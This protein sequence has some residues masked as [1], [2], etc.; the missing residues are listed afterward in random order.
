MTSAFFF[1]A[2]RRYWY[3]LIA[4]LMI[5]AFA[6][7]AVGSVVPKTYDAT[8]QILLSAPKVTDPTDSSLYV[9]DRM[10]TYAEFIESESVLANARSLMGTD[11]STAFLASH[12]DARVEV[13]TVLITITASWSD[14]QGAAD[15][16]N[17]VARSYAEVAPRLDN[18]D[19]PILRSDTVEA[20]VAPN[21]D[22][23]L[24]PMALMT[25]GST[26]GLTAGL[27][28]ALLWRIYGPYA[29]TIEDIGESADAEVLAVVSVPL[30]RGAH[31]ADSPASRHS[32][33]RKRGRAGGS[34]AALYSGAGL[35]GQG[36]GPRLVVVVS[37]VDGA[38]AATVGWG[39]AAT[40]AASGQRC[41]LV[42]VDAAARTALESHAGWTPAAK[43]GNVPQLLTSDAFNT[44]EGG[45]TTVDGVNMLL[46]SAA[47]SKDLVVIAAP[48]LDADANTRAFVQI[49]GQTLL[50]TPLRGS[51]RET[52][53][54]AA[55]L[56]GQAGASILGVVATIP[57]VSGPQAALPAEVGLESEP[58]R[59]GAR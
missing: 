44:A 19:D 33:P 10:P 21:A 8:A 9:R 22:A 39:L 26:A 29:R 23:G 14:P 32:S 30:G 55:Q 51:R 15:L 49:A 2:I 54:T 25:I 34:F 53:R 41:L 40:S 5:G 20:A 12:I 50:A 6:S 28:A 16:A 36:A 4:G 58:E 3:L 57:D 13:S 43:P 42:A 11:E 37:T 45:V 56:I 1:S 17:A 47:G 35:A 48:P 59:I 38:H 24:S 46:R 7:V 27:I 18:R 52:L 31:S